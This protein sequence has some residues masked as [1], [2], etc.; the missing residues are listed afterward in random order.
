M[1][2]LATVLI[3]ILML[4][5][6]NAS[7]LS[8]GDP[9]HGHGSGLSATFMQYRT[10]AVESVNNLHSG[11]DIAASPGDNVYSGLTDGTATYYSSTTNGAVFV[12]NAALGSASEFVMYYHIDPN[13]LL[14]PG[15]TITHSSIVASVNNTHRHVHIEHLIGSNLNY[16]SVSSCRNAM[17]TFAFSTS[18]E[19]RLGCGPRT[20]GRRSIRPSAP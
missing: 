15:S 1:K 17:K 5:A 6:S 3:H 7:G 10:I 14:T 18:S 8:F 20:P 9:L 16:N 19:T 11:V 13:Q 4:I 12:S 2:Y